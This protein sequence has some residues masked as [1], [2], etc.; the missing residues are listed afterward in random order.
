M[1]QLEDEYVA[2]MR[3]ARMGPNA[4]LEE[5]LAIYRAEIEEQA[6]AEVARQAG[7]CHPPCQLQCRFASRTSRPLVLFSLQGML[8][9]ARCG[10]A[11]SVSFCVLLGRRWS[12]SARWRWRLPGW[13]RPAR[14]GG[15]WRASGWSWT[16]CTGSAWPSCGPGR[17]RC[18]TSCGGSRWEGLAWTRTGWNGCCMEWVEGRQGQLGSWAQGYGWLWEGRAEVYAGCG[19]GRWEVLA[20]TTRPC[21]VFAWSALVNSN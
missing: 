17:R 5:R 11:E 9:V 16:A 13:T 1:K 8:T 3:A 6:A 2:K 19:G 20:V 15:S 21:A 14:R 7:P 4:G 12:A 18:W 10:V